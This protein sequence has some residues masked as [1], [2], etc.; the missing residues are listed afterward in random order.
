MYEKIR[1]NQFPSFL[2]LYRGCSIFYQFIFPC[3]RFVNIFL[4]IEITPMELCEVISYYFR[5]RNQDVIFVSLV[6][7]EGGLII[8]IYGL[9][10]TKIFTS[11]QLCDS[12]KPQKSNCR[13]D[14]LAD[15]K[16]VYIRCTL[17]C[18]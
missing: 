8:D 2:T 7:M 16:L 6:S 11:L 9:S 5:F 1:I 3:N 14:T 4:R 10:I 15:L 17:V 18:K 12:P 13:N